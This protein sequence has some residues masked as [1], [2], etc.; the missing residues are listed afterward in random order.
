MDTLS[1]AVL[2]DMLAELAERRP[3]PAGNSRFDECVTVIRACIHLLGNSPANPDYSNKIRGALS[4]LAG[5]AK[6]NGEFTIARRLKLLLDRSGLRKSS[7]LF[8][9]GLPGERQRASHLP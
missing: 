3:E 8:S 2:K 9:G 1:F 4:E 5:I 7:M 6:E